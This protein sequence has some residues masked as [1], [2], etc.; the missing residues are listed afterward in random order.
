MLHTTPRL[1]SE[2]AE[3]TEDSP[4]VKELKQHS[5]EDWFVSK[6]DYFSVP[7]LDIPKLEG[8]EWPY[9][10]NSLFQKTIPEKYTFFDEENPHRIFPYVKD[11]KEG[12]IYPVWSTFRK[13]SL[14]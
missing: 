8:K 11:F 12:F 5:M 10:K 14:P 6:I 2:N 7:S 3:Q 4:E 13:L 9:D 1:K